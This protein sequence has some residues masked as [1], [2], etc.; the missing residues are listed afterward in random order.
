MLKKIYYFIARKKKYP[1]DIDEAHD[2]LDVI[3]E[4]LDISFGE[5]FYKLIKSVFI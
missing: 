5:R 3:W 4:N 1:F 2:P